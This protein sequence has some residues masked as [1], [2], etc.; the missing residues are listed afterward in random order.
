MPKCSSLQCTELVNTAWRGWVGPSRDGSYS[1]GNIRL[2]Q[3]IYCDSVQEKKLKYCASKCILFFFFWLSI[4]KELSVLQ[5]PS[6]ICLMMSKCFRFQMYE[7]AVFSVSLA[8][9]LKELYLNS[10]FKVLSG[11]D[12]PEQL[13]YTVLYFRIKQAQIPMLQVYNRRVHVC[14]ELISTPSPPFFSKSGN[15]CIDN[16]IYFQQ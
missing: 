5:S 4:L 16:I 14:V 12:R 11:K 1:P 6:S 3:S 13:N 2:C 10:A 8:L 7:P 15:S 9:P